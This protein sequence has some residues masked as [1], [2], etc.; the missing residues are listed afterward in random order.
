[1]LPCLGPPKWTQVM[2]DSI[3]ENGNPRT[4]GDHY[5]PHGPTLALDLSVRILKLLW[6][7]CFEQYRRTFGNFVSWECIEIWSN[8]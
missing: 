4:L 7:F 3:R 2:L 1:M 6:Q 8:C 5:R